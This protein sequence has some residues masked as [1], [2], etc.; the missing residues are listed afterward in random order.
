MNYRFVWLLAAMMWG[1]AFGQDRLFTTTEMGTAYKK[2]TR[3]ENGAPGPN[4]WQNAADYRIKVNFDPATRLVS[5]TVEI[6]YRNA[7]PDTLRQL[8]FKLFPNLYQKG[9]P[10]SASI[11]HKDLHDGVSV[12]GLSVAGRTIESGRLRIDGT[13]MV[14]PVQPILPKTTTRV[15]LTYSY[16][17][18]KGSHTRTGEVE[19][20]AYFIAY[21]FPRITVYDDIDG[22]NRHPYLGSYEFYNDFGNYDVEIT[23]PGSYV[24]WATGDL[25]N[26]S[27]VLNPKYAERLKRAETADAIIDVIDTADVK[28]KDITRANAVNTWKFRAAN[29]SDFAFALS[30]HYVWKSTSLVVDPK[31]GRRTRVDAAFNPA[32][33]DFEEVTA[34]GRKTVEV[35]SYTFP[36]WPFPY[37]HETIFDGLDQMEYPMMVNDNPLENRNETITLTDHEVFHTMFPF[38]M[39]TNEVKHAWMDE[40]WATIGEWVVS[41][42]IEPTFD[43]DYGIAPYSRSAG[44]GADIPIVIPTTHQT[45]LS[46]FL[47]SYAKPGMGYYYVRDLLGE[48]LFTKALHQYIAQWNGKHPTPNDF[49]Y[50]MNA[51]AGRNLNW[52]W[53]AWF[54]DDGVPDLAVTSVTVA[55][56]VK[57]VVTRKGSK[58]VPVDLNVV[59]DDNSQENIHRTIA[60]WE[61]GARELTLTFTPKRAVKEVR[62]G[63]LYTPDS[64]PRNNVYTVKRK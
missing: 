12:T 49:F 32:H 58:P 26:V 9:A 47:N 3:S 42:I 19:E 39:G 51:G 45:G 24:V 41:K 56:E 23:A 5:G 57:V 7:S 6:D 14:V 1:A 27:D 50:S 64:D 13:N 31:T 35:M 17:L 33:K 54:F 55:K 38:Y 21:F 37:S 22:W 2:G 36:K 52:F 25:Q 15:Q 61:K 53:K 34:F 40:G 48:E 60:V 46:N 28:R 43:D 10:R 4:Y 20:G 11:S 59:Y 16:T 30:D 62:L 44:S 63:S 18:N 29:V 8:W